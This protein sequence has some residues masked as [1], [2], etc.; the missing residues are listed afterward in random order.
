[1]IISYKYKMQDLLGACANI[2]KQHTH[3]QLEINARDI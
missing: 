1:M 2:I 3:A